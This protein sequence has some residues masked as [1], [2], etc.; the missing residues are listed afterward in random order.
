MF[1]SAFCSPFNVWEYFIYYQLNI[2]FPLL[3]NYLLVNITWSQEVFQDTHLGVAFRLAFCPS[4]LPTQFEGR[5]DNFMSEA[6]A[7]RM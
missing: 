6:T 3:S 7:S 1:Y 5:I 4:S 2:F